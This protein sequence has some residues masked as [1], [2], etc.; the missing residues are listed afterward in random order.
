MINF[1]KGL[2]K[3]INWYLSNN[4]WISEKLKEDYKIKRIGN[5]NIK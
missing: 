4:V 1:D 2:I 3:T 5:K